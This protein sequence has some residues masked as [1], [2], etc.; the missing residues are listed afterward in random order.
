MQWVEL[1][2]GDDAWIFMSNHSGELSKGRVLEVLDLSEHGFTGE[3]YLIEIPTGIEPVLEV[4]DGFTVS[5]SAD[6]PIGFL[7][8]VQHPANGDP[9]DSDPGVKNAVA[10][11][12]SSAAALPETKTKAPIWDLEDPSQA[13]TTS[14]EDYESSA[15]A[16]LAETFDEFLSRRREEKAKTRP[17]YIPAGL[18]RLLNR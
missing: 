17:W 12:K 10:A 13:W 11:L 16:M 14:I 8:R 4:R 6:K 5:D 9:L 2:K 18:A 15:P 7:R 3:H 1:K